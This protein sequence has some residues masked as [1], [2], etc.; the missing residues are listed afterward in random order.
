MIILYFSGISSLRDWPFLACRTGVSFSLFSGKWRQAQTS[1]ER[2]TRA[3]G[4]TCGRGLSPIFLGTGRNASTYACYLRI[5]SLSDDDDDGS[6]N[7][8]KKVSYVLSNYI[9]SIWNRRSI[10]QIEAIFL[11]LNSWKNLSR[12]KQRKESHRRMFMSS[13]KRRI[14]RAVVLLIKK[15]VVIVVVVSAP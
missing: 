14:R 3:T 6:E 4:D 2:E 9:A 5:G 11:E 10:C 12:F 1:E 15:I 13:I 8:A 7:V